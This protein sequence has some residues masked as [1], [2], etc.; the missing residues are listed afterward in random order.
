MCDTHRVRK[1]AVTH[2]G[3]VARDKPCPLRRRGLGRAS[4]QPPQR[5]A[6]AQPG[7]AAGAGLEA[8]DG[9]GDWKKQFVI[10]R[11]RT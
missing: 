5:R 7:D 6:A 9:I 10:R 8:A 4:L 3:V 11:V 2:H 1:G